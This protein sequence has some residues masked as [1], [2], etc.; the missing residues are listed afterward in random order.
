MFLVGVLGAR[1]PKKPGGPL[2]SLET[3]HLVDSPSTSTPMSLVPPV[4]AHRRTKPLK[5]STVR[6]PSPKTS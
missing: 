6:Y 5:E 1:F 4:M 2:L 3:R